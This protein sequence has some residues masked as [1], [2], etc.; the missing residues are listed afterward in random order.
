[1]NVSTETISRFERGVVLPS[2]KTMTLLAHFFGVSPE[3]LI[4]NT[5][6]KEEPVLLGEEAAEWD[7]KRNWVRKINDL[8]QSKDVNDLKAIYGILQRIARIQERE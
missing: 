2:L 7:M 5:S 4:P 3:S 6:R 1:M 8:L